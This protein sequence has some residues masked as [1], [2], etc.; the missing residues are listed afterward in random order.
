MAENLIA[1]EII[2]LSNAIKAKMAAGASI[3]NL[4]IGDFNPKLFP[5][6][7]YFS[8][9]IIQ[10]YKDGHTNYPMAN[11]MPE[12][13]EAVSY[14]INRS[15]QLEYS[16]DEVL[17]ASGGRPLIFSAYMSMVDPGDKVIYPVPSWNNNHYAYISD[18]QKIEVQTRPEDNFMPNAELLAPH[19]KDATL[20]ALC[21]PLNPTG[22][23]FSK[24]QLS[25]ICE[26]VLA[27]NKRRGPDEK[28]LYIFYD[29]IYSSLVYG[30]EGHLNPVMLY[31]ELRDYTIMMD[32]MSKGFCA[33]GVRLGWAFGPRH[34][35]DK[36]K[37]ICTHSGTWSPKAEQIAASKFLVNDEAVDDF[38][39]DLHVKL[40]A[41]LRGFYNGIQALKDKGFPVDAVTPQAALY[42]TVKIDAL[43]YTSP[44]GELLDS[45]AKVQSYILDQAGVALVPFN[46]FGAS[47]SPWCR[48]S[49]GTVAMDDI[50]KVLASLEN[51]IAKLHP[52]KQAH[53][54]I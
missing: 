7:Q 1:S 40:I 43:G 44:S 32:G 29:Q 37:A 17:I 10:A 25:G 19:V 23:I 12:L 48:L 11:G 45:Y 39:D 22:T 24:E 15:Q 18:A 3:Y 2:T 31:P 16:A 20:L 46:C 50:P 34:V 33:T 42:L 41:R 30:E 26:L 35:I 13:R 6:P 54:F 36:M 14:F 27:E 51:A 49:V 9:E 47:A 21:S 38:L 8:D 5:I 52:S 4:T 53:Q 28:P